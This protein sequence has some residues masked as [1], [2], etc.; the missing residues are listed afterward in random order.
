MCAALLGPWLEKPWNMCGTHCWCAWNWCC[1]HGF[2]KLL[3]AH[4]AVFV[5]QA[6]DHECSAVL[7]AW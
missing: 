4:P 5:N 2:K 3:E 1:W 7:L 6:E